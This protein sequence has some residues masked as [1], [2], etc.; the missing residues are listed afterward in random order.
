MNNRVEKQKPFIVRAGNTI[1]RPNVGKVIKWQVGLIA[2][3]GCLLAIITVDVAFAFITGASLHVF[4]HAYFALR[5]FRHM[6]ASNIHRAYISTNQGLTGKLMLFAVGFA[7]VFKFWPNVSLT[8]LFLGY[9]I[10][11]ISSWFLYPV[12]INRPPG[13]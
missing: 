10:L 3:C 7:L 8:A 12:L 6:G 4:P 2:I 11:Q 5:T 13:G 1:P 9:L